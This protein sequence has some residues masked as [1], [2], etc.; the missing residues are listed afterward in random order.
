VLAQSRP[1]E[2]GGTGFEEWRRDLG[3]QGWHL[4]RILLRGVTRG[5]G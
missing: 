4:S 5:P 1:F 2:R 3:Q